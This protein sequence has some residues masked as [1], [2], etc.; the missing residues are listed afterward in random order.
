[1]F[2]Y[3]HYGFIISILLFA[4]LLT[5]TCSRQSQDNQHSSPKLETIKDKAP[6]SKLTGGVNRRKVRPR[7]HLL[8]DISGRL[9]LPEDLNP[10]PR[11]REVI[12]QILLTVLTSKKAYGLSLDGILNRQN[13]DSLK[14]SGSTTYVGNLAKNFPDVCFSKLRAVQSGNY[15]IKSPE[16]MIDRFKYRSEHE[17]NKPSLGGDLEKLTKGI[18][19]SYNE[20]DS[21]GVNTLAA[22]EKYMSLIDSNDNFEEI[23]VVLT[24]GYVNTSRERVWSPSQIKRARKDSTYK[25]SLLRNSEQMQLRS[26]LIF[27]ETGGRDYDPMIGV[28]DELSDNDVLKDLWTHWANSAGFESIIWKTKWDNEISGEWIEKNIIE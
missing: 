13:L 14:I 8:S 18:K 25:S 19:D 11:D 27:L 28:K 24:D 16:G 12:R 17:K 21:K 3:Q 22:L 5:E 23:F 26:K 20:I 9:Y 2:I 4:L 1:M 6:G 7:I 15:S 10:A